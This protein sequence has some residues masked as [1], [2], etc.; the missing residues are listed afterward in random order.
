MPAFFI[1]SMISALLMAHWRLQPP[2]RVLELW[3]AS[4]TFLP[5]LFGLDFLEGVYWTLSV[6][7][8]FYLWVALLIAVGIWERRRLPIVAGWL[9]LGISNAYFLH[10]QIL[11]QLCALTFAGHFATGVILHTLMHRRANWLWAICLVPAICLMTR[12][13]L[14]TDSNDLIKL[15]YLP[16]WASWLVPWIVIGIVIAAISVPSVAPRGLASLLGKTS[17]P[18]Y[19]LHASLGTGIANALH[20]HVNAT[21]GNAI[22][23]PSIV[24]IAASVSLYAEAPLRNLMRRMLL[25]APSE[26]VMAADSAAVPLP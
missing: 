16:T 20:R 14:I 2:S 18:L 9:M 6:E 17:Y 11:D 4:L 5:H 22:A 24:M 23:V 8:T 12:F 3:I 19:L 13:A 10:S 21:L 26:T 15:Q 7:V 25:P 1:C